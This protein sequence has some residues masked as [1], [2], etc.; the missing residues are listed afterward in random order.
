[1]R[2]LAGSAV[3]ELIKKA[4]L[5]KGATDK[6]AEY[7]AEGLVSTSLRGVD[8]HGIRLIHHYLGVVDTGR[9]NVRPEYRITRKLPTTAILDADN[10]FGHAAGMEAVNLAVGMAAEFGSGYVA[11]A[12]SSHFGAAAYFGIEI[13]RHD[14]I[15]LSFTHSDSLI[16]PERGKRSYLG[17]NPICFTAPVQGE[18][19]FCLDMATSITTFN[20]IKRLRETG[21]TAPEGVGAD[22]DGLP[23]TDPNKIAML[24]PVGRYKGYGLSLMVEILCSLL[25]GMSFGSHI[26]KMFE[27]LGQ[28]RHLGHCFGAINISGFQEV[29]LF[30][31]RLSLLVNELRGEPPLDPGLPVLVAGDPEKHTEQERRTHGIPVTESEFQK[32]S[33][34][35]NTLG[36]DMELE[37]R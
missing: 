6:V 37:A 28:K 33:E 27:N 25:T 24:L 17:N 23:E 15:G 30:K 12:N 14:M 35:R 29:S 7:V 13:A 5:G 4:L 36:M 10:T 3:K 8:S 31:E 26:S 19:P 34:L 9:I 16:I 21:G 20:E 32:F 1:M 2:K 11:V 22:K 18:D